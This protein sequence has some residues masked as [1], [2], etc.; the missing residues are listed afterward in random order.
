MKKTGILLT[1]CLALVLAACGRAERPAAGGE[2]TL[3]E[4]RETGGEAPAEAGEEVEEETQVPEEPADE[5]PEE[6]APLRVVF[7][8]ASNFARWKDLADLFPEI[9]AVNTAISGS[10]DESQLEAAPEAVYAYEPD[11]VFIQ[12]ATNDFSRGM[13][14]DQVLETREVYYR[15]LE[16]NL[17]G[18]RFVIMAPLPQPGRP[19][20][21][22]AVKEST[23]WIHDWCRDHEAFD[24]ID[25]TDQM[26]LEE[27]PEEWAAG[28][29]TY[30][31]WELF[32]EDGIHI[33]QKGRAI[34][35]QALRTWLDQAGGAPG[36]E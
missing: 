7:Y 25:T 35:E 26:L 12:T 22:E 13:T 27:G 34:W 4:S 33:N 32:D 14:L 1:L 23:L 15:A 31:N 21:W 19:S 11:L 9:D 17:P 16:E 8:G 29:G 20:F 5:T 24:C 10:T 36:E 18:T 30:Y 3:E 6:T 28:D 2:E